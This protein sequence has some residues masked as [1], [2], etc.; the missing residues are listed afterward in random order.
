MATNQTGTKMIEKFD[1][2]YAF[3]S[4]FHP[5]WIAYEGIVYPTSEHAFQAAK[6]LDTTERQRI[7]AIATPGG[8]KRAGKKVTLRPNW[9][10]ERVN[11]MLTILRLKFADPELRSKLLSTGE[12]ELI[13][14]NTWNDTFWGVCRGKGQNMLGKLLMRVRSDERHGVC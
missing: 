5:C 6:T 3:L 4:N 7:A 9:N 12:Q 1:G 2:E 13:E 10:T 8:A 11:V 14:G